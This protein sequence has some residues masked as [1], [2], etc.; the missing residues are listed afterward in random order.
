MWPG[1]LLRPGGA[2][3][4]GCDGGF[5]GAGGGGSRFPEIKARY[6]GRAREDQ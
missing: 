6:V 3:E 2:E 1:G 5:G 4:G